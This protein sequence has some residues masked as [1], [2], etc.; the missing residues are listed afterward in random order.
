MFVY[1]VYRECGNIKQTFNILDIKQSLDL[2]A[3]K[4][5][6]GSFYILCMLY[7]HDSRIIHELA[8]VEVEYVLNSA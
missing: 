1:L 8:S 6:V 4:Y 5:E 3:L 2:K 7:L